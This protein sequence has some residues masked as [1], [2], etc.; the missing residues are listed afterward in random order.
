LS[1]LAAARV[2]LFYA[3]RHRRLLGRDKPRRFT[4]WVQWRKLHDRDHDLALLTDKARSK[5]FVE[6]ALGEAMVIP[7]LWE[8]DT[9]PP[10]PPWPMPFIV[11]ANHGCGRFAV[12]RTCAD[13]A[14][15]RRRTPTWLVRPYGVMLDEWH[16]RAARRHLLVEPYIGEPDALPLDYKIYVF[17]GRAAMV[18]LHEDRAKAHRWS[19]YDLEWR[20]LSAQRSAAPPPASLDTMIAAAELLA[21]GRDF[22]RVDFYEVGGKPLFGEFCLYPGSG[23]DPFNPPIIDDWLGSLWSACH[24]T[25]IVP[26]AVTSGEAVPAHSPR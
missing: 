3:W 21:E 13:Y 17:G 23:L 19:Q 7:T 2:E 25:K 22:L 5:A 24:V 10:H 20:Q 4:E 12:I 15:A 1:T 18:Q 8:G 26:R 14:R 6:A 11:K 9:L 16:Y